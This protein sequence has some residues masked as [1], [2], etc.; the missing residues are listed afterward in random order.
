MPKN[1]ALKPRTNVPG[2]DSGTAGIHDPHRR[3]LRSSTARSAMVSH[4][5]TQS[6]RRAFSVCGPD[7]WNNLPTHLRLIDSHA[8]F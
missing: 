6:G 8:F 1:Q 2:R 4:T 5:R 7:I 3:Q